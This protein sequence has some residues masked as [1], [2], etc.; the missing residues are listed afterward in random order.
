[1]QPAIT[2]PEN[3]SVLVIAPHIWGRAATL[4]DAIKQARK[5]GKVRQGEYEAW[6][7]PTD[8]SVNEFGQFSIHRD[9][10][11]CQQIIAPTKY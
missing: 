1:M 10:K 8:A 11:T 7:A 5:H 2:A 6:F 3:H 9:C 4:A